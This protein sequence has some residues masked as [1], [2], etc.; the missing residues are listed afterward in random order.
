[1]IGWMRNR[2]REAGPQA[3]TPVEPALLA[4]LEPEELSG[5]ERELEEL[6]TLRVP[7][8]ARERGWALVR[9]EV[10]S[11]QARG[12]FQVSAPPQSRRNW[13]S[14]AAAGFTMLALVLGSLG[15]HGLAN[16]RVAS[17]GS[18]ASTVA[19]ATG[20]SL[21][22]T[23]RTPGTSSPTSGLPGTVTE[24]TASST[25]GSGPASSTATSVTTTV[26]GQTQT[27]LQPVTTATTLSPTTARTTVITQQSTSTTRRMMTK[28]ERENTAVGAVSYLAQAVIAGSGA[29]A[30]SQVASSA[31]SGLAQL[32]DS[33]ENPSGY[34]IEPLGQ[35][36]NGDVG[37]V[38]KIDD[39]RVDAQGEP[40][41]TLV[42]FVVNVRVSPDSALIV[43]IY[44]A[45]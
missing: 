15:I 42:R 33:L 22:T 23:G 36:G 30:A 12:A 37:V 32:V 11:R 38:L 25:T 19:M 18:S 29:D 8:A 44:S 41:P 17:D 34:S 6:G 2:A 16:L 10:A 43:A 3:E 45:P 21:E 1:M 13:R 39:L 28:E 7:A 27:T 14:V 40:V 26:T 24:A 4:A 9:Q 31:A 5:L 35:N 20:S